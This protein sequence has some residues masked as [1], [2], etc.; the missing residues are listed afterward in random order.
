MLE[1]V[2]AR[3]WVCFCREPFDSP[4][5]VLEYLSRYTHRVAI[6]NGRLLDIADGQVTFSY[7]DRKDNG[8]RKEQ[9]VSADEFIRR[10]LLH[11]LPRGLFRMRHY[12]ILANRFKAQRLARCRRTD[13]P[14][15]AR[16]SG[17]ADRPQGAAAGLDRRG[18]DGMSGMRP[19]QDGG[20]G[21]VRAPP[22]GVR[23]AGRAAACAVCGRHV[24]EGE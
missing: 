2:A 24:V 20:G 21:N 4:Q 22:A 12:G 13:G 16:E 9:T 5:K 7:L 3:H 10:F 8:R 6:G 19:G 23:I 14:G 11:V 15:G 18:H 17:I 1:A